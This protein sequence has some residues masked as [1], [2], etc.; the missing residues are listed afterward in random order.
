VNGVGALVSFPSWA[1]TVYL[2]AGT[3][4]RF[5]VQPGDE[6]VPAQTMMNV[7]LLPGPRD[8]TS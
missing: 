3:G 6:L 4:L 5:A 1:T 8:R 2:P 7:A